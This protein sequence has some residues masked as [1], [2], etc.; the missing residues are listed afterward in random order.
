MPKVLTSVLA[1]C[2]GLAIAAS[3]GAAEPSVHPDSSS[4]PDLFATDL[5]NAVYPEGVWSFDGGVLT[6]TKDECIWTSPGR[7]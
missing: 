7:K 1:L 3:V 6:A 2:T 4:W 5:S